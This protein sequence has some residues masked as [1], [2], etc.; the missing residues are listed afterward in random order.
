VVGAE[1]QLGQ[2][3]V[4][5]LGSAA[6][7]S[8]G[9]DALDVC[10]PAAVERVL[11]AARPDVV[12]NAAA[13]NAV[14]RAELEVEAA[15]RVNA[16]APAH[17]GRVARGLHALLV[18]VSTDYVFDGRRRR[19]YVES[20]RPAPLSIYGASKA[21]GEL[22][23]AAAAPD[24]LIVRTSGVFGRGGSRA[25]G[26]SFV[27]RILAKARA[28]E[29][30]RVVNDQVF[31]PTYA[32]DLAAALVTLVERGARG[33]RHVANAGAC[34]WH[35]LATTALRLARIDAPVARVRAA[36]LAL[37]AR[38]PARSVLRSRQ[39]DT[40]AMRPWEQALQAFL[41]ALDATRGRA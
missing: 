41:G 9:R 18:H 13:W 7:W 12:F 31:A 30:L 39:P 11:S 4:A 37:P 20:D 3:L 23:A 16:V 24:C 5:R 33:V 29:A 28:G 36:E 6:V 38:R 2:A 15:F 34:S 40:P 27:E 17:L 25:K 10:D 1:G 32:P 26:G 35:G 14:D 8:G 22:A 19:P 21:A